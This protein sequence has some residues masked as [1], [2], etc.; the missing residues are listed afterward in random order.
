MHELRDDVLVGIGNRRRRA[1]ALGQRT[2]QRAAFI[3]LLQVGDTLLAAGVEIGIRNV[4]WK[5]F[6]SVALA[7]ATCAALRSSGT[8]NMPNMSEL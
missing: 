2:V 1:I 7:S 3:G 8:L 4:D 5:L 6:D